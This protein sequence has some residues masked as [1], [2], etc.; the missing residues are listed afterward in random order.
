MMLKQ[1][2]IVIVATLGVPLWGQTNVY[3]I[4]GRLIR[5]IHA[6]GK[7]TLYEYDS[8]DNLK[9]VQ[10]V[11]VPVAAD[12]LQVERTTETSAQLSWTDNADSETGYRIERRSAL[13]YHWTEL[14]E[15]AADAESYLDATLINGVTYVYRILA[16]GADD[17]TSSYTAEVTAA[18]E[19]S[20][21]FNLKQLRYVSN[22][23]TYPLEVQFESEDTV[24]YRLET[25]ETL[26]EG[27]WV[28]ASFALDPSAVETQTQVLGTG[29]P[30][31]VYLSIPSDPVFYRLLKVEESE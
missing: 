11:D 1:L 7:A 19:Y 12:G 14:A 31:V 8:A 18:G 28:E 30:I 23:V 21:P 5:V 10:N 27:S 22:T 6:A 25:S 2:I 29:L 15:V 16:L 4:E 3:D 17:L 24:V 13:G 9:S 26:A 20:L